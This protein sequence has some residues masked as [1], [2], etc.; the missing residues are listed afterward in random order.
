[1]SVPSCI[2]HHHQPLS[3][4]S[5][6][7]L[8]PF[9]CIT[10]LSTSGRP[11]NNFAVLK[12]E[13]ETLNSPMQSTLEFKQMSNRCLIVILFLSHSLVIH[14]IFFVFSKSLCFLL[15]LWLASWPFTQSFLIFSAVTP[16]IE[17]FDRL[18]SRPPSPPLY[19]FK[20][21]FAFCFSITGSDN[22]LPTQRF[23]KIIT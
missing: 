11:N 6:P 22:C 17:I 9:L 13:W 7:Q 19:T 4:P 20:F 3:Y 8:I 12:R 23:V 5:L 15:T 10:I 1:M 18:C 21:L 2:I 16:L 14:Q